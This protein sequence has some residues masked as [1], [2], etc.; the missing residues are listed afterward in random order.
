MN[1]QIPYIWPSVSVGSSSLDSTSSIS[2]SNFDWKLLESKNRVDSMQWTK[3]ML[4]IFADTSSGTR[5][6]P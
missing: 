3:L 4:D 2:S 5:R 1:A 6:M